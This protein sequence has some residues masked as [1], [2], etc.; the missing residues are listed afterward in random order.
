MIRIEIDI[1]KPFLTLL[2]ILG[3]GGIFYWNHYASAKEISMQ[4]SVGGESHEVALDGI[5]SAEDEMRLLRAQQVIMQNREEILRF[6]LKSIEEERRKLGANISNETVGELD[7]STKLLLQLLKDQ[8]ETEDRIHTSLKQ[9]WEAEGD[10]LA[11]TNDQPDMVG[12]IWLT[13]PVDPLYSLSA[14]FKDAEY[15]AMFGLEHK[16]IDI[17][18]EQG[19]Q[20]VAASDGVVEKVADNGYGFNYLI[21][22]HGVVDTLYGH[23][24]SFLVAEGDTVVKGQ[25]IALSG[26]RPGS[27]GA[28]ALTTGPHLHFE[29]IQNGKRIDPLWML[30][31]HKNVKR[32]VRE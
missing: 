6:Q 19:T 32:P 9:L 17:P 20:V 8:K 2:M 29:V 13:W 16:G 5:Q 28:G 31:R 26:G 27:P 30:P 10:L 22:D 24:E 14:I 21:L 25:P 23:V 11:A 18:T 15:Q 4:A 7:R 3:I 1:P 12:N